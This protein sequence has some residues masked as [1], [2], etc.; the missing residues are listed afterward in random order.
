LGWACGTWRGV[1]RVLVGKLQG[2]RRPRHRWEGNNK[3]DFHEEGCEGMGW[4]VL[5]QDRDRW[6]V[7]V[8]EV[9]KLRVPYNGRNFLTS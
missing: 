9:M 5:A 2:K 3:M 6:W 7:L 4:I 1:N 8:N